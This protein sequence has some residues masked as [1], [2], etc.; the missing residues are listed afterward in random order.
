MPRYRIV[1]GYRESPSKP[2][3]IVAI[4]DDMG[5]LLNRVKALA[6]DFNVLSTRP[7]SYVESLTI[8]VNPGQFFEKVIELDTLRSQLEHLRK[9]IKHEKPAPK[10]TENNEDAKPFRIGKT[11]LATRLKGRIW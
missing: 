8:D 9:P 2:E 3:A 11:S 1:E 5:P 7:A 4:D 10:K 6:P